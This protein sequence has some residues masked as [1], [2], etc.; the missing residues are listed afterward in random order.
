EL[1]ATRL[2]VGANLSDA[3]EILRDA[4]VARRDAASRRHNRRWLHEHRPA[5][6]EREAG[7]WREVEIDAALLML[8]ERVRA[9][10]AERVTCVEHSAAPGAVCTN[11]PL[12]R[13][14]PRYQRHTRRRVREDSS[15]RPVS[16]LTRD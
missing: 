13:V 16:A 15:V 11:R 9:I 7:R 3:I 8:V 14:I 12:R 10:D 6:V 2:Q 1:C 4:C 5:V